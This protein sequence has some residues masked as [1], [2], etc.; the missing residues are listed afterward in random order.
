MIPARVPNPLKPSTRERLPGSEKYI[1]N[2][3]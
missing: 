3:M 2:H 1:S